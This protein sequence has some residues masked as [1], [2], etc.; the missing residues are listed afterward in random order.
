MPLLSFRGGKFCWSGLYSDLYGVVQSSDWSTGNCCRKVKEI[1]T[2][3]EI[4]TKIA[5]CGDVT[6][7]RLVYLP[8]DGRTVAAILS[9]VQQ[10]QFYIVNY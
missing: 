1:T 2:V 8:T 10:Q 5:D 7:C 6:P 3:Q 9:V 4:N